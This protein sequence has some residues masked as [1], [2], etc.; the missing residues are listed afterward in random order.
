MPVDTGNLAG[1]IALVTGASRGIGRAIARRLAAGGLAVA[2]GCHR[3][4]AAAET[5]CREIRAAGGQAIAVAGDL[6]DATTPARMVSR[7]E[8]ELGPV[9]VLVS[10]AGEARNGSLS[11]VGVD[12]WD[13]TL[14]GHL[15]AAFLLA[16][17]VAGGMSA[18]GWGR[19]VVISSAAAFTGGIVGPHYTAAKAGQIGLVRALSA[20]LTASGVTVNAVA[21]ALVET[22]MLAGLPDSRRERLA[23]R[24]PAGRFGRPEEVAQVV[25]ML[26]GNG[27]LSGQTISLDGGL[28]P[29]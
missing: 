4:T 8:A 3:N 6:A 27:Y 13:R 29:R 25:W 5:L 11:E 23:T 24:I 16:Q 15:R 28:H 20:A 22:D 21:P 7:V 26:L 14:N 2:A 18:R 9:E 19:I 12:T 17:R 10:N 1:R